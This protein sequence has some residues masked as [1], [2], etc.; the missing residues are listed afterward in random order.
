MERL[1]DNALIYG[2]LIRIHQ[3]HLIERY[4]QALTAFGL[5]ETECKDFAIDATGFSPEVAEDLDDEH[6]LDPLG[7]NRRFIILS[8]AQA[9]LPVIY[10]NFS[11]TIDLMRAFFKANAEAVKVLT[12]KDVLYGEIENS[13]Y[14]VDDIDDVLSI[15]RVRFSLRTHNQLLEKSKRL[16]EMVERF[17]AED[18]AWKDNKLLHGILELARDC[19]D[20]RYN[21]IVPQHTEF[22]IKS[23]WTRHFGG[24]YVFHDD[25][26]ETVV[27]GNMTTPMPLASKRTSERYIHMSDHQAVFE[28]LTATGR[29]EPLNLDWLEHSEILDLRLEI[30]TRMAL[31]KE[32]PEADLVWIG[33]VATKNWVHRN[34][35]Q[36][37]RDEAFSFLSELCRAIRNGLIV[38]PDEFTATQALMVQRAMPGHPDS[39]LVNRFLTE[40][41]PFDFLTR[42]IVN[43]L[44]FYV[45]YE[46]F[47]TAQR[48]YAVHVIKTRYFADKPAIWQKLFD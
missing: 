36:L 31:S 40:F 25:G 13:T 10:V 5:R 26:G 28:Y 9:D 14:K 37:E 4:N 46:G 24:V 43:K 3:P 18:N 39:P 45:D 47:N 30:C 35:D 8:P 48:D 21:A 42:F 33:E 34:L 22:E 20:T 12:L 6:Y 19:G 29:L 44:A 38:N 11:S 23:F 17:H 15:K 1:I 16:T 32:R 41:V 27:I 2:G 7:V